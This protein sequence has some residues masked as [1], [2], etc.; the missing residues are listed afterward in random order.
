MSHGVQFDFNYTWSKCIDLGSSPESSGSSSGMIINPYDQNQMKAVCNY[1]ATHVFSALSVVQLPFGQGR[2]LLNTS[3]KF[4]N[5]I[6]GGWQVSG[7]LTAASGFPVSV[8]NGGVYPT[9]WNSSG[10]ATQT[11]IAPGPN[12]TENAPSAAA[13]QKGGP[14]IFAVPALAYAAY[15]QTPA[16]QTGQRNGIRGQGPFSLDMGLGKR[17]NLYKVKDQQHTL[18]FRAEGFNITNSVRFDPGG[19]SLNIANQSKFGQYTSTLETPRVFQFAA[20]YEF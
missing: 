17:F 4:V 16:G 8:T 1:D 10:Y 7:V 14:N 13:N 12:S 2:A 18:Q 3:N 9:E 15:S 19:A 20:R 6:F 5:G 11:G